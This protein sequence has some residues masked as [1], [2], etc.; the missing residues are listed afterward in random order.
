MYQRYRALRALKRFFSP[1]RRRCAPHGG[2]ARP[3]EGEGRFAPPGGAARRREGEGRSAPPGG[4]ARRREG[5]GRSRPPIARFAGSSVFARYARSNAF[6]TAL[7]A[8]ARIV[9]SSVFARFAR[10]NAFR[11]RE[12]PEHNPHDPKAK[13]R[14]KKFFLQKSLNLPPNPESGK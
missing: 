7:R 4:A 13:A 6:R 1:L 3:R 9:H 2:A 5:E 10:S 8:S 14:E 12:P 11:V